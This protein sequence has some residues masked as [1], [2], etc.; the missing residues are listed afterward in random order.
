MPTNTNPNQV[1]ES[2]AININMSGNAQ[3]SLNGPL[4]YADHGS[5]NT[6]T[7]AAPATTG[8]TAKTPFWKSGVFWAAVAALAAV[9]GAIA[10]FK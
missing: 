2:A 1:R 7:T 10:A 6:V 3:L 5:T 9:A 4:N 8:T